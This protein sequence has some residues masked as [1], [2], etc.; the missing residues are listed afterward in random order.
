MGR[1]DNCHSCGSICKSY[2]EILCKKLHLKTRLGRRS[3]LEKLLAFCAGCESSSRALEGPYRLIQPQDLMSLRP[4]SILPIVKSSVRSLRG[5][6]HLL[7]RQDP[8]GM[9]AL[10][11]RC[12]EIEGGKMSFLREGLSLIKKYSKNEQ[13][14]SWKF[15]NYKD[16]DV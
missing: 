16:Y 13:K 7:T 10:I 15:N 3:K 8:C 4:G 12:V 5:L 9:L 6:I 14:I 2:S 1:Y 11:M